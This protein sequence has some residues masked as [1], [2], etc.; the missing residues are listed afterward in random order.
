MTK[1]SEWPL[2]ICFE[3]SEIDEIL[4]KPRKLA[5]IA[6]S[7]LW[8][9]QT[10]RRTLQFLSVLSIVMQTA[11]FGL[12]SF[13][14]WPT[15]LLCKSE[16]VLSELAVA[17]VH[18]IRNDNPRFLKISPPHVWRPTSSQSAEKLFKFCVTFD[19]VHCDFISRQLPLSARKPSDRIW[20]FE[21][22]KL[23]TRSEINQFIFANWQGLFATGR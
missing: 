18:R 21:N 22:K 12:F 7:S 8:S 15:V 1:N 6:R 23:H 5:A 2:G 9:W 11:C 10:L 4:S 16:K 20:I 3:E 13:S 14:M 19:A 17:A